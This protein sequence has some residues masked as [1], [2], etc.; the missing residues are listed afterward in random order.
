MS[1]LDHQPTNNNFLSPFNFKFQI[2]KTPNLNFFV[3]TV[4]IPGISIPPVD[5][6]NPLVA[7]PHSGDHIMYD[8]ILMSFKVD[9]DLANYLEIHNWIRALG[10][11]ERY[12]EYRA[13]SKLAQT[14]GLGIKSDISLLVLNSNQVPKFNVVFK[15]AFPI[16]LSSIIFDTTQEDLMYIDASATFRYRNYD[17]EIM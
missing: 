17:I 12:A 8:E 9:E 1:A 2:K 16:Q 15:D 10:F 4:N 6:H 11:P 3:Q 14:S 5:Q 13:L 7:I